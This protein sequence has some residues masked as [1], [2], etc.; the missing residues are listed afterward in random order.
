MEVYESVGKSVISGVKKAQK[1]KQMHFMAVKKSG[2][3]T[4]FVVY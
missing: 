3:R 2:K 4:C 1:G